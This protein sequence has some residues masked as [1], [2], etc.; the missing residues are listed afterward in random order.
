MLFRSSAVAPITIDFPQNALLVSGGFLLGE[1]LFSGELCWTLQR[2]QRRG[3]PDC[4]KIRLAVGSVRGFPGLRSN[5][6]GGK[7]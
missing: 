7:N 3:V 6:T 5:T 1:K 4:L 2:R